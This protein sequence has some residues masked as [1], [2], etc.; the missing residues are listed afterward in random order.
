MSEKPKIINILIAK[1]NTPLAS[2]SEHTGEFIQQC[3]TILNEVQ[4]NKSA[5]INLNNGYTVYYINENE[6]TFLV[7][8]DTLFAQATIIACIESIK[9]EF[10]STYAGR[11]FDSEREYGL[12]DEFQNKL[13]MKYEYFNENEGATSEIIQQ[14][15]TEMNNMKNQII[16]AQ[17]SLQ[18]RGDNINRTTQKASELLIESESHKSNAIKVRKGEKKKNVWMWIGTIFIILLIIYFIACIVCKSFTFQCS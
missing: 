2:Y 3:E 14:L 13:K 18:E 10:Q 9:K 5:S 4:E 12:N 6:I 17:Y 7:M 15:N 11:D 8:A 1:G 16:E